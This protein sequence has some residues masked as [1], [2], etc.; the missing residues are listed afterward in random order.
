MVPRGMEQ[1]GGHMGGGAEYTT[2]ILRETNEYARTSQHTLVE[3][4]CYTYCLDCTSLYGTNAQ[5]KVCS[6]QL[7]GVLQGFALALLYSATKH[8]LPA[9]F[10]ASYFV[11]PIPLSKAR[12]L[13]HE[14]PPLISEMLHSGSLS[15]RGWP[16]SAEFSTI[17]SC[18]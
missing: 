11:P 3:V 7:I 14:T 4:G 16:V 2:R 5:E 17:P 10:A 18:T 13:A 15:P 9:T 6:V 1:R 8:E 12:C